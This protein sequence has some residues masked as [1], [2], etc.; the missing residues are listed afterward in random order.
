V[1]RHD[2]GTTVALRA[3]PDYDTLFGVDFNP[4]PAA[5]TPEQ[6]GVTPEQT[7]DGERAEASAPQSG[8]EPGPMTGDQLEPATPAVRLPRTLVLPPPALTR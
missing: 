1:R 6:T 4:V 8:P 7:G 2:D 3:L 5:V